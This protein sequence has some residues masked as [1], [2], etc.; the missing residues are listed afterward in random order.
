MKILQVAYNQRTPL[1][2]DL[3]VTGYALVKEYPLDSFDNE[4]YFIKEMDE[5]RDILY[6]LVGISRNIEDYSLPISIKVENEQLNSEVL[7]DVPFIV[8]TLPQYTSRPGIILSSPYILRRGTN[9]SW[10]AKAQETFFKDFKLLIYFEEAEGKNLQKYKDLVIYET[11]YN[12]K[13][14]D[15]LDSTHILTAVHKF[16]YSTVFVKNLLFIPTMVFDEANAHI[17]YGFDTK[18]S[19]MRGGKERELLTD[20]EYLSE[21]FIGNYFYINLD[22]FDLDY[23]TGDVITLNEIFGSGINLNISISAERYMA[24]N[25]LISPTTVIEFKPGLRLI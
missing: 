18:M 4:T 1:D 25:P 8:L 20:N 7:S 17:V 10:K 21:R 12:T 15:Q 5:Y 6:N 23:T 19:I 9:I 2:K 3:I 16:N 14:Y 24:Y 22:Q 13:R 11:L